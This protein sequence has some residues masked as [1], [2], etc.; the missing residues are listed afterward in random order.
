MPVPAFNMVVPTPWFSVASRWYLA[1][2]KVV[3]SA[4]A[5]PKSFDSDGG[6]HSAAC[7]VPQQTAEI[8]RN[9]REVVDNFTTNKPILPTGYFENAEERVGF[10]PNLCASPALSELCSKRWFPSMSREGVSYLAPHLERS[11]PGIDTNRR[12]GF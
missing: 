5:P 8:Q 7:L 3:G 11:E 4:M 1:L 6:C 12:H 9:I 10:R 2:M